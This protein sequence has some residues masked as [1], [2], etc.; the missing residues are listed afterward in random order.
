MIVTFLACSTDTT[1]LTVAV[2]HMLVPRCLVLPPAQGHL[3]PAVDELQ[4][5][6]R[7]GGAGWGADTSGG[8][9]VVVGVGDGA[10]ATMTSGVV[11]RT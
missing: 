2:G 3:V 4:V 7:Q 11:H 10:A 6:G 8:G 1:A 9:G 5:R